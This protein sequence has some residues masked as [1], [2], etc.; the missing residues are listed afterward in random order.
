MAS[1]P[2]DGGPAPNILV[3]YGPDRRRLSCRLIYEESHAL[4]VG[5]MQ[6]GF[7]RY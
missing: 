1:P 3:L 5:L 4:E 2:S 6:R 7:P